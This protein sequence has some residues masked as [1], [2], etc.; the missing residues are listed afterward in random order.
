M[1]V[2]AG[3]ARGIKLD[4]IAG[5][6]TR[7]TTDRV[8]EA[9]FSMIHH[10]IIHSKGLDLFSGSGALGI[11]LL[12]RGAEHVIFVEKNKALRSVLEKNLK[13]TK[14]NEKGKVIIG[15]VQQALKHFESHSFDIIL[16]DPPYLT[17]DFQKTLLDIA[18]L[19]LLKPN[20]LVL[21]EYHVDD[22]NFDFD[23]SYFVEEKRKKYGKIGVSLMRR[24]K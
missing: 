13:K 11:E 20:G 16:M 9:V 4:T 19:D 10:E 8:K 17:G 6:E 7:P 5:L 21:V 22:V 3:S 2:I 1:R 24:I 23:H 12:S 14:F 15:D 18:R